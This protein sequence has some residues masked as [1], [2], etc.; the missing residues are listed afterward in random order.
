MP[1]APDAPAAESFGYAVH[2]VLHAR[3]CIERGRPWQAEYWISA[4]RDKALHLA[5]R[6]RGLEGWFGR[7]FDRLP[8]KTLEPATAALVR[9]LDA[10]E[11]NRALSSAVALLLDESTEAA[12]L[13]DKVRGQLHELTSDVAS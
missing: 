4:A 10:A 13:A 8:Q 11:L 2:H 7:D 5:C 12:E 3:V 1:Q 9:S 6:R